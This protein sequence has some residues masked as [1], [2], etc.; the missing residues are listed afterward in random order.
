METN[1]GARQLRQ[2]CGMRQPRRDGAF[3][4]HL[5]E[6]DRAARELADSLHM[7]ERNPVGLPLRN[8]RTGL[9]EVRGHRGG[10][11]LLRF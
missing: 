3:W 1:S 4:H 9:P 2:R 10:T 11:P 5:F 6:G 7:G 8:R